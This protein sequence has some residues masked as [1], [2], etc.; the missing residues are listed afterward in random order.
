M[1]SLFS[2]DDE[3]MVTCKYG[4]WWELNEQ[5]GRANNSAVLERDKITEKNL[6]TFG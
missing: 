5:R 4:A 6:K 3:E 2:F 1:I